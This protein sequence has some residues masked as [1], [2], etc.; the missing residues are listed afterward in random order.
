MQRSSRIPFLV[1]CAIAMAWLNQ[2]MKHSEAQAKAESLSSPFRGPLDVARYF[3][4]LV[5][6][7]SR[8]EEI[9][10][11][12]A[13]AMRGLPYDRERLF[14]RGVGTPAS[15]DRPPVAFAVATVRG[16]LAARARTEA[17]ATLSI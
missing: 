4:V 2:G 11:A 9:Y 1:A 5:Y 12:V 10:Y 3:R 8:D 16:L 17:P 7:R 13:S 14:D 15:F 6:M